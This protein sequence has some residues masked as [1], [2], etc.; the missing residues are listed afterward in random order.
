MKQT[1]AVSIFTGIIWTTALAASIILGCKEFM[2]YL[3]VAPFLMVALALLHMKIKLPISMLWAFSGLFLVHCLGGLIT[4]PE[5]LPTEGKHLL[6]NFWIIPEKLKYDQVIHLYGNALA[7]WL[8]WNLLRYS[9]SNV[10]K[11]DIK[12]I[13]ARPTFLII[14]FQAGVGVGALNEV[15][16]FGATGSVPGDTNVGG[17]VNTGWDLV[18]NTLGGAIAI[19]L[20]WL[21]RRAGRLPAPHKKRTAHK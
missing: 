3:V 21:K 15:L 6:Y 13:P 5:H 12:D 17:Y 18:A 4:L 8:C 2:L 9:I 7:T 19:F 10:V 16:E 14:C 20:I 11:I 1:W